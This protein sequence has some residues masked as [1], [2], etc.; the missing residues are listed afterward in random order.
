MATT[1]QTTIRK[2]LIL[3][4][5]EQWDTWILSLRSKVDRYNLW[6]YIDPDAA[7]EDVPKLVEPTTPAYDSVKAG[8]TRLADLN[9]EER[10][11]LSR[12]RICEAKEGTKE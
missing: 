4:N 7:A 11:E 6:P 8:A 3:T 10:L 2:E 1:T 9:T 5:H 12:T